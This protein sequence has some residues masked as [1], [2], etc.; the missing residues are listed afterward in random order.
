MHSSN[1]DMAVNW[2]KGVKADGNEAMETPY[3]WATILVF[4]GLIVLFL[5]RSQGEERDHLWQYLVAALG[6]ALT[7]Y[8]GNEAIKAG[9]LLYHLAAIAV[10]VGTLAFIWF[11]LRPL[12]P[13]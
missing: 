8:L 3:D 1:G 7:N 5:Q 4:A 6:C 9:E 2:C 10:G 12:S 13:P 11:S